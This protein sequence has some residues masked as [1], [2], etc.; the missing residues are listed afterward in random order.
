MNGEIVLNECE[1]RI[2]EMFLPLGDKT[3]Y[4]IYWQGH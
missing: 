3:Q 2:E 4:V 1:Q